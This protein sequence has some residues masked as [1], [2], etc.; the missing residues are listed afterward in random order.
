MPASP[1]PVRRPSGPTSPSTPVPNPLRRNQSTFGSSALPSPTRIT[2]SHRSSAQSATGA[3]QR[4]A[5]RQDLRDFYG[6]RKEDGVV[7]SPVA[8]E[9]VGRNPLDIGEIAHCIQRSVW[10]HTEA[11]LG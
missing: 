9:A 2:P 10:E 6:L 7:G 4:K 8:E 11:R 5:R 1:V 3:E